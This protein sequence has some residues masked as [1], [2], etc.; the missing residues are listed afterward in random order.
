M[1]TTLLLIPILLLTLTNCNK[2]TK[3]AD[4]IVEVAG[5]DYADDLCIYWINK[6]KESN[7]G[8][9]MRLELSN[10]QATINGF[11]SDRFKFNFP[12]YIGA[13]NTPDIPQH[14]NSG[15]KIHINLYKSKKGKKGDKLGELD[16]VCSDFSDD[17][18]LGRIEVE[19]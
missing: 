3:E 4:Y 15:D 7:G 9:S 11:K 1:K 5:D 2:E 18:N 19:W 16:L 17:G 8:T 12:A 10:G 6:T 13:E 14:Q